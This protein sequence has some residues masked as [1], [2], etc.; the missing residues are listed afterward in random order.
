MFPKAGGLLVL[1]AAMLGGCAMWTRTPAHNVSYDYS[2]NAFYDH[3]Y[4]Q[5]PVYASNF[6]QN[7]RVVPSVTDDEPAPVLAKS[8]PE[9]KAEGAAGIPE[10]LVSVPPPVEA[11][12]KSASQGT[13]VR[14][15]TSAGSTRS[16]E[17]SSAA[18]DR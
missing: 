16:G 12:A 13:V 4:A 18:A 1:M 9:Q 15:T 14:Q 17:S 7:A 2:D 5:S 11:P 3:P 10:V 8:V 6:V